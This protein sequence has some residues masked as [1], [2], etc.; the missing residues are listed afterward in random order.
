MRD[1]Q[2]ALP[3]LQLRAVLRGEVSD[4]AQALALPPVRVGGV[5]HGHLVPSLQVQFVGVSGLEVV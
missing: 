2:R 1:L 5:Y 3:C 4:L